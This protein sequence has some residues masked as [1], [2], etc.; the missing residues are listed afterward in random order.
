[1]IE[2][3]SRKW[4]KR[5]LSRYIGSINQVAGIK[6]L[7]A[8]DGFERGGRLFEVWTGSGL[9]FHVLAD[10]ALDIST[11]QYKGMSLT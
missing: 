2:L 9:S 3:Y 7:E 5:D 1:M 6:S 8:S 10:R 4:T 11:C